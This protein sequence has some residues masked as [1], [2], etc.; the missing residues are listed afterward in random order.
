MKY[1]VQNANSISAA[2]KTQ[3]LLPDA[4]TTLTNRF[5][6]LKAFARDFQPDPIKPKAVAQARFVTAGATT[7]KNPTNFESG[8]STVGNVPITPSQY[9][10]SFHVSNDELNSGLRMRDLITVNASNHAKAIWDGEIA[11]LLTAAN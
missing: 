5:G 11:P 9:T 7:Q 3:F 10:T 4:V 1:N 6:P 8:D 2:L